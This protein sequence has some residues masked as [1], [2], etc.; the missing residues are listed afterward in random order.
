MKL[1][2]FDEAFTEGADDWFLFGGLVIEESRWRIIERI[3]ESLSDEAREVFNDDLTE[4]PK[5]HYDNNLR[6]EASETIY[7]HLDFLGFTPIVAL[8]DQT[9]ALRW[10]K[11][12]EPSDIY[13]IAFSNVV[14]RF[15]MYLQKKND[16][17]IMFIDERD[18]KSFK[19]LREYHYEIKEQGTDYVDPEN[20][21]GVAA[22]LRDDKSNG[23]ALADWMVSATGTHLIRGNSD[24]YRHLYDN[25]DRHPRTD[26]VKGVGVKVIPERSIGKL[27]KHPDEV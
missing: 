5:P 21:V 26:E 24:Y 11:V 18:D 22:P 7:G 3:E 8:V 13:N 14:E 16:P 12:E 1:G 2:Y 15:Q 25:F 20:I 23:M 4:I 17:G 27:E 6:S 10:N 19:D 9:E